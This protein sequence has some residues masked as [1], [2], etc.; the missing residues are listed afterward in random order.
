M[1]ERIPRRKPEEKG[2]AIVRYPQKRVPLTIRDALLAEIDR[3]VEE[4]DA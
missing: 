2:N 4:A 1:I 3:F